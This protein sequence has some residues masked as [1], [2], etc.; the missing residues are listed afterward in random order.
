MHQENV[1]D[2]GETRRMPTVKLW[3]ATSAIARS[4]FAANA[5]GAM[6][7]AGGRRYIWL[8]LTQACSRLTG[9]HIWQI[10][11]TAQLQL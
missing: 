7:E 5:L 4:T 11:P 8:K 3:S 2:V 10:L 9:S 1:R 6:G